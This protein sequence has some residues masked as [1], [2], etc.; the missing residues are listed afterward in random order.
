[1]KFRGL[2]QTFIIRIPAIWNVPIRKDI[3]W[4]NRITEKDKIAA[5]Q[6]ALMKNKADC[7]SFTFEKDCE[8]IGIERQLSVRGG[9]L[10]DKILE[11]E[12]EVVQVPAEI[13]EQN[14]EETV[15]RF[16]NT[17]TKI[18]AESPVFGI[19]EVEFGIC[20]GAD[21]AYLLHLP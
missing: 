13:I 21:G 19:D 10:V 15:C 1:M 8:E 20:V 17:L 11:K 3:C 16:V 5:E 6:G 9:S 12:A 4:I 18:D 7:I 14:M 2:T